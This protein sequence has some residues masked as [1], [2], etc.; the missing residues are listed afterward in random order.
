MTGMQASDWSVVFYYPTDV[1]LALFSDHVLF[2][3]DFEEHQNTS[4]ASYTSLTMSL[5]P[6][7]V[8]TLL[9][10]WSLWTGSGLVTFNETT[11]PSST[12]LVQ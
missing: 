8:P 4:L 9:S 6:F 12:A 3:T 11:P 7:T 10:S 1:N 2:F 5:S